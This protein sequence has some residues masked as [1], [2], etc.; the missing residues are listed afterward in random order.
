MLLAIESSTQTLSVALFK[1]APFEKGGQGGIS[2]ACLAEKFWTPQQKIRAGEKILPLIDEIFQEQKITL[3]KITAIAINIGPGSY[4]GLRIGLAVT[5]GLTQNRPIKIYPVSAL[6]SLVMDERVPDGL[7]LAALQ[8]RT[9]ALYTGLYQKLDQS[10][11]TIWPD[12][13]LGYSE[14]VN[15][16]AGKKI[17][18]VGEILDGI[19]TIPIQLSAQLLGKFVLQ[20]KPQSVFVADIRLNYL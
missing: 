3:D 13:V 7:I 8:A 1:F 5:M 17:V 11:E 14:L 9:D 16:V 6:A 15:K 2:Y 10:L 12:V 19:S 18:A 4:T 20:T